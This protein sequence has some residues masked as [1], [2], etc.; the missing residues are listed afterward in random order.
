MHKHSNATVTLLVVLVVFLSAYVL[1]GNRHPVSPATQKVSPVSDTFGALSVSPSSGPVGTAVSLT[2]EGMNSNAIQRVYFKNATGGASF[3]YDPKLNPFK[4][5]V[6]PSRIELNNFTCSPN[7]TECLPP[8]GDTQPGDYDI[9]VTYPREDGTI[10]STNTVKFT[11]LPNISAETTNWKT[12]TSK[13][14]MSI[15][16]P[17]GW[18]VTDASFEYNGQ[19]TLFVWVYGPARNAPL[20]YGSTRAQFEMPVCYRNYGFTNKCYGDYE[21]LGL[22]YPGGT[23]APNDIVIKKEDVQNT[24]EYK[25]AIQILATAKVQ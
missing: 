3:N 14:G 11:V 25:T 12:F 17:E 1:I 20:A 24:D 9:Y 5:F 22:L 21:M 6:I 4:T 13:I 2:V 19:K 16:Y 15:K 8:D 23:Q 18:N 10:V 7:A